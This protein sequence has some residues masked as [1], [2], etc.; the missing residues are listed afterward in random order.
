MKI[1][2]DF[3]SRAEP[4]HSAP[5][6]SRERQPSAYPLKTAQIGLR[7]ERYEIPSTP[8]HAL[9]GAVRQQLLCETLAGIGF[10]FYGERLGLR[11]NLTGHIRLRKLALLDWKERLT[12]CTIEEKQDTLFR[13]LGNSI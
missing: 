11:R 9:L 4:P 3:G 12:V 5:H 10:W 2:T 7:C 13:R 6:R 1:T 8:T